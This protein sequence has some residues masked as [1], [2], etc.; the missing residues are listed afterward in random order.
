V[1]VETLEEVKNSEKTDKDLRLENWYKGW[2]GQAKSIGLEFH[3]PGQY[4]GLMAE[5]MD[6]AIRLGAIELKE[7]EDKPGISSQGKEAFKFEAE[8]SEKRLKTWL[9]EWGTQ[10]KDRGM[11]WQPPGLNNGS[12]N[13]FIEEAKYLGAIVI[14]EPQLK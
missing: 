12:L 5:F 9:D 10:A 8:E 4:N 1:K 3:M 2:M 7:Y 13:V 6:E 14:K 11:R